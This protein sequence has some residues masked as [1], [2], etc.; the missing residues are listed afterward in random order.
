MALRAIALGAALVLGALALAHAARAAAPDDLARIEDYLNDLRSLRAGFVQIAPDGSLATG[1]LYYERP[2]KMRLDYDPPSQILIVAHG[3]TLT[4]YDGRLR[5]VN[6]MFTSQ[7][8]L[9]FLLDDEIRLGGDVE[10]TDF[11]Q[12]DDE[13]EVA[14][15]DAD[16]PGAGSLRLVFGTEPLELRRWAVTDAQGLTTQIVLEDVETGIPLDDDLFVF[17][18]PDR[19]RDRD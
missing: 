2:D 19:W 1:T 14:V 18:D 16:D 4:Y 6:R 8:P 12:V 11:A 7:T 17:R 9:G 3:I 10:V 5:Q 15:V 13:I